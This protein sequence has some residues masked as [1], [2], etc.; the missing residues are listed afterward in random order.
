MS[1]ENEIDPVTVFLSKD[2]R[3]QDMLDIKLLCDLDLKQSIYD[4]M[5]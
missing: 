2:R 1:L 4:E 3:K 5:V